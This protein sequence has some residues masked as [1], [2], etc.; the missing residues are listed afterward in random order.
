M[1]LIK[2]IWKTHT[3][4]TSTSGK[5]RITGTVFTLPPETNQNNWPKYKRK[6]CFQDTG[7][8]ATK[9]RD[10]WEMGNK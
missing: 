7:H 10:L 5:G 8:P 2:F 1:P 3:L 6:N 4:R 9:N